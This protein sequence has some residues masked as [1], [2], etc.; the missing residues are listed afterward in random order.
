M[1]GIKR[2]PVSRRRK[3]TVTQTI[4]KIAKASPAQISTREKSAS[5]GCGR[6]GAAGEKSVGIDRLITR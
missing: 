6:F 3:E 5:E 4:L 1:R 2:L